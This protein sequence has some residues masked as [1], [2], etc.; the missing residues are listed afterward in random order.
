MSE[1]STPDVGFPQLRLQPATDGDV[2]ACRG[3]VQSGVEV[4]AWTG[5]WFT[6]PLDAGALVAHLAAAN[7]ASSG[8]CCFAMRETSTKRSVGYAEL[9]SIDA[10]AARAD[11]SRLI[12]DPA[13]RGMGLGARLKELL[14][15]EGAR[16]GITA[17]YLR[18]F[19][20]NAV[21]LRLY[22]RL[23][24]SRTG[25]VLDRVVLGGER[26]SAIEMSLVRSSGTTP[27]PSTVTSH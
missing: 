17:F 14:V 6:H 22:E 10:A 26:W 8:R 25:V 12:V 5:A 1:G 9:T 11:L 2:L 16:L 20:R 18:V 23:G 19:E 13:V 27:P 4:A 24:F 21:A 7:D 15:D 3:W